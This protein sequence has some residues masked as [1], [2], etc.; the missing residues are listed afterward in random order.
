MMRHAIWVVAAAMGCVEA[1]YATTEPPE[2]SG[3][4]DTGSAPATP[5]D[6]QVAFQ[7]TY[8]AP[9]A[10]LF[11]W[12][13]DDGETAELR[14]SGPDGFEAMVPGLSGSTHTLQALADGEYHATVT[15][16][17]ADGSQSAASLTQL[18]GTNRLVYRSEVPL[19][20]AMDVWGTGD[21]AVVGG[22]TNSRTSA[23]VVDLSTA[24]QPDVLHTM[25]GIGFVRDVKVFD[26]LLFTAVDPNSDG[27]ELCDDIGVRIYEFSNPAEPKLLSTIGSPAWAVHNMTYSN[28]HLYLASM[29]EGSVAVFDVRDP[30]EPTR[31]A[32]WYSQEAPGFA[33][34]PG[35]STHDMTAQG[36]RLYVAHVT[37]FSIVDIADPTN[38]TTLSDTRV[39]M[40]MHN[41][42]PNADGTR[43]VG[44]QEIFGG[45]L[46]LWDI[47]DPENIALLDSRSNGDDRCVHNAYF[48]GD[49]VFAAWYID[50]VYSFTVDD[51]TLVETGHYDTYDGA[52]PAPPDGAPPPGPPIEGA[53]GL[54]TYGDHV[55]VGDTE[56]GMVV[57]DHFPRVV[58]Q[59]SYR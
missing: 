47:S 30:A 50:G 8:N 6:G 10:L 55:V 4:A 46:S 56:R 13:M 25:T 31:V 32:T 59:S 22:G 35:G 52:P 17:H 34:G 44:T 24:T 42:W 12:T 5:V 20:R 29:A 18:V 9:D 48:D 45:A 26:D 38:P 3:V 49:T 39:N 23:L 51:D 2:T 7:G 41:V 57:V 54:W 37:G 40:G 15:V 14:V 43:L 19:D 36:D 28:G 11:E 58:K 53:W 1:Q 27:C 16:R 21:V 33:H